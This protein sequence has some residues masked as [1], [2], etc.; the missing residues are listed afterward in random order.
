M[1]DAYDDGI[2]L[3]A[4]AGNDGNTDLNYPASYDTVLR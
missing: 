2:L 3:V 4:S 1:Q